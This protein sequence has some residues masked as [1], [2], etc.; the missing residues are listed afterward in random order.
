MKGVE[1]V[2]MPFSLPIEM[3]DTGELTAGMTSL[4]G[5]VAPCKTVWKNC[6]W[7]WP[8]LIRGRTN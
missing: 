5:A 2:G 1:I 6:L 7:A 3:P 8:K 4:A